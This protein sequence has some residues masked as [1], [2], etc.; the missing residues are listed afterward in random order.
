MKSSNKLGIVFLVGILI[1]AAFYV[2]FN[3]VKPEGP[4]GVKPEEP[5]VVWNFPSVDSSNCVACHTSE[6]IISASTYNEDNPP[7]E[8]TGG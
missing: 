7:P 5:K 4:I 3:F 2:H 1:A 8:D 6:A